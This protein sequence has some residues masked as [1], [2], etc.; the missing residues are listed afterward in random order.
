[1]TDAAGLTIEQAVFYAYQTGSP[2]TSSFTGVNYQ[3]WD[4]PPDDV[5]S[6]V[7]FGDDTTNRIEATGWTDV[8]RYAENNV[9][10]TQRPVMYV[11]GEAGVHLPT[12][13]YW[14]DW[15]LAGS[16]ASGPWQPPITI[17][18]ETTTGNALQLASTGWQPFEDG[19]ISTAQGAPFQLWGDPEFDCDDPAD[20]S[21]LDVSPDSGTTP[22]GVT[23]QVE[24]TL[25]STG[26]APGTY[27]ANLCILSN[28]PATPVVVV[29]VT[30]TVVEV[31]YGV[32]LAPATAAQSGEPGDMV[33]YTLTITNTGNVSDTFTLMASG[34][35][36]DVD[37]PD[38]VEL[39][40]GEST[41]FAVT[42]TIPANAEDGDMDTV[43]VTATSTGDPDQSASSEL[44]TTAE[45]ET[46]PEGT[47]LYLPIVIRN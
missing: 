9:G 37:L 1:V 47:V 21:W 27:M 39:G 18:G 33:A 28:D 44:T 19:G 46:E 11:V 40:A 3:I 15:Q 6:A 16:I 5:G 4:G 32:E 30:M 45:E 17:I 20:L 34:N 7:I 2:T 13:T 25:D 36:W 14:I 38:D 35:D 23:D 29:P 22:G 31:E 8:Y 41:T 12:G 10:N 43:T 24:V 26:V 42:V